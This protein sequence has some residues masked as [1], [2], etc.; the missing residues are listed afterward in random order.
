MKTL[1]SHTTDVA[2]SGQ[3]LV[4][5][6]CLCYFSVGVIKITRENQLKEVSLW[7]TVHS[8]ACHGRE[9][10]QEKPEVAGDTVSKS[11]RE[12]Q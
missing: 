5:V 11:G 4:E 12:E 8:T 10:R 2:W 1:D 3:S 7:L 6:P 9:K